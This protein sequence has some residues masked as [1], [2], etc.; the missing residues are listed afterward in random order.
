[1]AG[2]KRG[3][4]NP[5][6]GKKVYAVVFQGANT[7]NSGNTFAA[8]TRAIMNANTVA[9]TEQDLS[10]VFTGNFPVGITT[11]GRYGVLL[12]E[13]AGG[14]P[15]VVADTPLAPAPPIDWTGTVLATI[16]TVI[17]SGGTAFRTTYPMTKNTAFG[18]FMFVMLD[19]PTHL[20]KSGL[21][22]GVAATRDLDN[23]AFVTCANA[24]TVIANGWYAINLAAADLNGNNVAL[25]FTASNA[26]DTDIS[27]VL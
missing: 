1:M 26:D 20:P 18:N 21:G 27:L 13:Q 24:A 7:W 10:G 16:G 25:R 15:S 22:G 2:E 11:P 12:Y 9:L 14:S 6:V 3:T 19:S 23:S 4:D 17:N 8:P 5:G